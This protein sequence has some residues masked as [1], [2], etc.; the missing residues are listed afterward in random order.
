MGSSP[1]KMCAVYLFFE[2]A[3]WSLYLRLLCYT[4]LL[5]HSFCVGCFIYL[6]GD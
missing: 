5:S 3:S 1:L 2:N 4:S 6:R